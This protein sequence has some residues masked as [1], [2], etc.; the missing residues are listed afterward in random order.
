[1][2]DVEP[3]VDALLT[4]LEQALSGLGDQSAPLDRLVS[5]HERA[6]RLLREAERRLE[7]LG[8]EARLLQERITPD[9]P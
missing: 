1:V 3:S 5:D 8:E 4:G 6:S 9:R 2:A 7:R